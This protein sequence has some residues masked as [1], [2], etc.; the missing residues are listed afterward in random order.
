VGQTTPNIGRMITG[1]VSLVILIIL[2]TIGGY[3]VVFYSFK[4]YFDAIHYAIQL[5]VPV[6]G[7]KNA[8]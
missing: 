3:N 5:G 4:G 1:V 2:L 7:S 8:P 6:N